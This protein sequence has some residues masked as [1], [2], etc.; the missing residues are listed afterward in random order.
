MCPTAAW[1]NVVSTGTYGLDNTKRVERGVKV[2]LQTLCLVCPFSA[3]S[4][5]A[6]QKTHIASPHTDRMTPLIIEQ[7]TNKDVMEV[8]GGWHHL[9]RREVFPVSC[10]SQAENPPRPH[11]VRLSGPWRQGVGSGWGQEL[12]GWLQDGCVIQACVKQPTVVRASVR[13]DQAEPGPS[14]QPSPG[15]AL[16]GCDGAGTACPEIAQIRHSKRN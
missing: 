10:F 4:N 8:G 16:L 9:R 5:C 7:D 12:A 14:R 11:P 13:G 6:A 1:K 2:C 15:H 3:S